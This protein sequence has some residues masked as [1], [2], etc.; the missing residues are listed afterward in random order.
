MLA[1]EVGEGFVVGRSE[2][3]GHQRTAEAVGAVGCG[4]N[5]TLIEHLAVEASRCQTQVAPL[6]VGRVLSRRRAF[7]RDQAEVE[8]VGAADAFQYLASSLVALVR[9]HRHDDPFV[10]PDD[11]V[12]NHRGA[13]RQP[14]GQGFLGPVENLRVPHAGPLFIEACEVGA[15][16][17]A[18]AARQIEA[19]V[20]GRFAVG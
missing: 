13:A 6:I 18:D 7:V 20:N 10:T 14:P 4:N 12:G 11:H 2:A 15:I 1:R 17:H 9:G 8:P 5:R 19:E 16:D 3:K